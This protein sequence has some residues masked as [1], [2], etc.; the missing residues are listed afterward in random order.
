MTASSISCS[1]FRVV[2]LIAA[3]FAGSIVVAT[4]GV[5]GAT[6]DSQLLAEGRQAFQALPKDM[7]TPEF[8]ITPE[9][10]ELGRALFFDPRVSVDSTT[11]CARCHAPSLYG[12]DSL[13]KPRGAH[14]KIN[15]RNAPTVLN[16]ALQ[17]NAHWRGDRKNVEDQATQALISPTSF[18]NPDYSAAM[19]R[20]SAIPGYTEMFQK[21]FPGEETPVTPEN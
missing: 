17:F 12:T 11:S 4:F 2:A 10:V 19:R 16:A 5:N 6:D 20:V 9:R 3:A 1:R 7:A 13:S 18:G 14:D 8:P 15:P 21:A